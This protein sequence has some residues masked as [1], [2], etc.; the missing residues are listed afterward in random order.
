[1]TDPVPIIWLVLIEASRPIMRGQPGETR[2]ALTHRALTR[3]PF[4]PVTHCLIEDTPILTLLAPVQ[5][6]IQEPAQGPVQ[7]PDAPPAKPLTKGQQLWR[8]RKQR[9]ALAERHRQHWIDKDDA[10]KKKT[11]PSRE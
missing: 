5:E 11:P 9:K 4:L 1:M 8:E 3:W 7:E 2:E 6:T 10:K